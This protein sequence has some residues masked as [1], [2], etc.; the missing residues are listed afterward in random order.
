MRTFNASLASALLAVGEAVGLIW[1]AGQSREKMEAYELHRDRH[2][3][4]RTRTQRKAEATSK[5]L[6]AHA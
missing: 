6:R 2:L 3:A 5:N 4:G 1:G